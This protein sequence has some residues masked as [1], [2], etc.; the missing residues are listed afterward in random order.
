MLLRY[1]DL[2]GYYCCYY[3]FPQPPGTRKDQ[4]PS[5][6]VRQLSELLTALRKTSCRYRTLRTR[7][8]SLQSRKGR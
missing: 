7:S 3:R 2:A 6:G 5:L 1:Y 4:L 8:S